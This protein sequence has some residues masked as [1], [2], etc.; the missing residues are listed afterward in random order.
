M[1]H[2]QENVNPKCMLNL[3]D[4][5]DLPYSQENTMRMKR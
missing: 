3:I 1:S 4:Q 5:P 2:D